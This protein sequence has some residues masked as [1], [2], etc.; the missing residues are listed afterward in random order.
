M[1]LSNP[2]LD[3]KLPELGD[4]R[5]KSKIA[6]IPTKVYNHATNLVVWT[7]F[8]RYWSLQ[9]C[10]ELFNYADQAL[11]N[12][13]QEIKVY[14]EDGILTPEIILKGDIDE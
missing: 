12:V 11:Y 3:K 10:N 2:K 6:W 7:W 8:E 14:E 5:V 13:W 4:K 9:K 1:K